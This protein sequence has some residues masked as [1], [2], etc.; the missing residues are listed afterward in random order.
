MDQHLQR[1]HG[2]AGII[3]AALFVAD[4]GKPTFA[5]EPSRVAVDGCFAR[6][7]TNWV[8]LDEIVIIHQNPD[9]PELISFT[10]RGSSDINAQAILSEADWKKIVAAWMACNAAGISP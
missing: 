3:L 2:A 10:L 1:W 9:S 6:V 4:S 7:D 8:L 5:I